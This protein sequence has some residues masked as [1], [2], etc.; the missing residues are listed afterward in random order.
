[1]AGTSCSKCRHF[2]VCRIKHNR[3]TDMQR[4]VQD[5]KKGLVAVD[6]AYEALAFICDYFELK[7]GG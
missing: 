2:N 4:I 6:D 3:L 7:E 1:M 5:C